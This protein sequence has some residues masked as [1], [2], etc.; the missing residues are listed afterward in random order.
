LALE[1]TNKKFI[2]RFK[3]LEKKALESGKL[4]TDMTLEEMDVY[5][6]EA[7]TL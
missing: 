3:Y 7:K 1:R 4:L 2:F 5:W 6:N